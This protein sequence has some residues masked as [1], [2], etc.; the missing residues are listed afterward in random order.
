MMTAL[1]L[2]G[3]IADEVFAAAIHAGWTQRAIRASPRPGRISCRDR[4][5]KLLA[6]P[7]T[8]GWAFDVLSQERARHM[9]ATWSTDLQYV[10]ETPAI[11]P[12]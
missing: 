6:L 10:L 4:K 7:N 12:S 2:Q 8:R 5:P 11:D 1:S 9:Q 3:R